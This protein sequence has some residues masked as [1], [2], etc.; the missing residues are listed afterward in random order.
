MK[1]L[2]FTQFGSLETLRVADLPLPEPQADEVLVEVHAAGLNPSDVKNVLGRFPYT[3]LPRVPGRDFAGVVVKGPRE[4]CGREVWGSGRDLGFLRDGSHAEYLTL[5]ANALAYKPA[6]LSFAQ[7]ASCGVPYITALDALNRSAVQAGTRVLIMGAGAVGSA[8]LALARA[9]GAQV[10]GAVRR[11]AQALELRQADIP[12]VTLVEGT[13]LQELLKPYF[14]GGAE[15]IFD[16]TGFCLPAAVTALA[17]FG[18]I[19]VIAAPVEGVVQLPVLDLYRRGGSIIG[20]NSLLYDTAVCA[21][22][23]DHIAA[24]FDQGR[25]PPPSDLRCMPLTQGLSAYAEMN[26]GSTGKIVL[27]VNHDQ[28]G[29]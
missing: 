26:R 12:V 8:A 3:T 5:P 19:A 28:P 7:A 13:S 22:M 20:I 29:S 10:V 16:T 2:Q 6:S 1:A 17:T 15:V 9:R 25:L 11:P 23:L 27:E 18:R 21:A 14:A 24:E 4:L